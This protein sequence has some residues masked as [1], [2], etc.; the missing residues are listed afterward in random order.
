VQDYTNSRASTSSTTSSGASGAQSYNENAAV[1]KR[2]GEHKVTQA[3]AKSKSKAKKANGHKD[4]DRDRKDPR[5]DAK[6][7]R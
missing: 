7:E 6:D 3:D 5:R 2:G 4:K 1:A